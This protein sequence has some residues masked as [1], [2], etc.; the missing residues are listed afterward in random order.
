MNI[1]LI[2]GELKLDC[3]SFSKQT[4]INYLKENIFSSNIE[5]WSNYGIYKSYRLVKDKL[6]II[7][8]FK[9]NILTMI[10][11]YPVDK[12]IS[13][14]LEEFGGEQNYPWGQVLLNDDK[15]A[16]YM[17]VLIKFKCLSG[18]LPQAS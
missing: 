9:N 15:K 16:G 3:L 18:T 5:L 6:I 4:E 14:I 8:H 12:D 13:C 17:S 7:L 11:I 10:E 2:T 1:D